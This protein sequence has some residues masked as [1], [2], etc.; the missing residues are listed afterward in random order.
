MD[1]SILFLPNNKNPRINIYDNVNLNYW[2][3]RE[4]RKYSEFQLVGLQLY[5][6]N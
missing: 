5:A 1:L 4:R 3:N 6:F 2:D